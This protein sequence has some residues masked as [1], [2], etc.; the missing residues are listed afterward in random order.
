MVTRA[1]SCAVAIAFGL[2]FGG[3]DFAKTLEIATRCGQDS[4]CNPSSAGGVLGVILGYDRIPAR[5]KDGV[6]ALAQRK[7]DF[8]AYS[9]DDIVA[10]T[11]RR[12]LK[13]I[14]ATGGRVT[15]ADVE[16]RVQSPKAPRLEQWNPGLPDR[17]IPVSDAAW[18]FGSAWR[19]DR[20][21]RIAKGAGSE[22]TLHFR[23][24]AVAVLG[25]LSQEGGRAEVYLDG[26]KQKLPLDAYIVERTFD[27][28]LW[29]TYGLKPGD[30]TLRIMATGA[31]DPRSRGHEVLVTEAVVYRAVR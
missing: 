29:Q 11:E 5:F 12:A 15:D 10:S 30:H 13:V 3:G 23:G 20:S 2:L 16:V 26:V 9:F 22:V 24:V 19:D 4:D 8:T 17:R 1:T 6:P 21:G 25:S 28:V 18:T 14:S 7:F 27:N 31:A